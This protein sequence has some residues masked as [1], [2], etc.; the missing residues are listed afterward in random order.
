ME[1]QSVEASRSPATLSSD[2]VYSVIRPDGTT[3]PERDPK[4]PLEQV[5]D[6][7]R[8]MVRTRSLDIQLER[9]QRQGRIGFH[10]GSLGEEATVVGSVAAFAE[11]DWV[12]PCYR[13]FGAILWR[14]L[15][16]QTYV[17]N[18]YGNADDVVSGRQMPDHYTGR[19]YHYGSVSSPIGTQ[20]TQAVGFAWAGLLKKEKF[21]VGVYFGDGATSSN[22][23]HTGLNFAGV[24]KTPT[25]FLCRNN[26]WAISVPSERQTASENFAIKGVAYGVPG[27]RCDGNDLLAAYA[28]TRR[29]VEAARAGGGSTLIEFLTYRLGGHST[30]DDPR[31]YR[32]QDEV[33][34]WRKTDPIVRLRAYLEHRDAWDD[35]REESLKDQVEKELRACIDHAEKVAPPALASMF[36]D[37]FEEVPWHLEE[38]REALLQGPRA[39]G[40]H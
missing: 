16:L 28:V 7:Y 21:A 33:E 6:L 27:V 5:L 8:H 9:L 2:D 29:A 19:P 1:T 4:L 24:F 39:K 3:D 15:P 31:A 30:S 14:G 11:Q 37:V 20:I 13:E 23:F 25:V 10:I 18:M 17:N 38:Q 36:E 26:R 32:A 22:E 40:H 35:D 34:A 12:F